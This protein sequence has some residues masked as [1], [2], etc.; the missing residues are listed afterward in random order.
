MSQT[1]LVSLPTYDAGFD[2]ATTGLAQST[3]T[4]T[5]SVAEG[6]ATNAQL[7]RACQA[8]ANAYVATI[9]HMSF[10]LLGT[11]KGAPEDRQ[12]VY[13]RPLRWKLMGFSP[14][15]R[16]SDNT[17]FVS[18]QEGFL[19]SRHADPAHQGRLYFHWSVD[20][21]TEIFETRVRDY[22]SRLVG[23]RAFWLARF[24]YIWTQMLAHRYVSWR[25][26]RWVWRQRLALLDDKQD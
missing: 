11:V 25:Y 13:F 15:Q 9:Q 10:G 23:K 17:Y 4:T 8:A 22:T 26:H 16:E 1:E 14:L 7:D 2:V 12:V 19:K 6:Q 20:E 24:F 5:W 21:K 18:V 3:E